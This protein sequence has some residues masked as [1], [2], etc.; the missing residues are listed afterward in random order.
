M[1]VTRNG[2]MFAREHEAYA[3]AARLDAQMERGIA[4]K[5]KSAYPNLQAEHQALRTRGEGALGDVFCYETSDD[6]P[7]VLNL[8]VQE[9][10]DRV[11]PSALESAI[12]SMYVL[13]QERDLRDVAMPKMC[14]GGGP[15]TEER[16]FEALGVI[17]KDSFR[18]VTVYEPVS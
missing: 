10:P 17:R 3:R 12:E 15:L 9:S 1:I 7:A 14:G 16:F 11:S 4:L 18:H 2:D 8:V 13:M 5:F 6:R